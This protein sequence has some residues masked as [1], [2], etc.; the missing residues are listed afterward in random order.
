MSVPNIGVITEQNDLGLGFSKLSQNDQ[1]T[2]SESYG[3]AE[4]QKINQSSFN[5]TENDKRNNK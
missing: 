5:N 2:Y 1:K 4:Q 3:S